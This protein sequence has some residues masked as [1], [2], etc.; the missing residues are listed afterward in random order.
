MIDLPEM[1][2]RDAMD[3]LI[4]KAEA[5]ELPEEVARALARLFKHPEKLFCWEPDVSLTS[6]VRTT[7]FSQGLQASNL[8]VKLV[9]AVRALDW[10]IVIVA[11]KQ[12]GA[13][14]LDAHV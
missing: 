4:G 9:L 1:S 12:H 5:H 13:T 6:Q 2:C 14:P 11:G 7:N 3:E 10:E 8:L